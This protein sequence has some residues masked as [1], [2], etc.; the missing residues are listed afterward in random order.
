MITT[1]L[2]LNRDHNGRPC[3]KFI[4]LESQ[5]SDKMIFRVTNSIY[6]FDHFYFTWASWYDRN[7]SQKYDMS[8]IVQ[9]SKRC[10]L[11]FEDTQKCTQLWLFSVWPIALEPHPVL[12][13]FLFAR[14]KIQIIITILSLIT[15][16]ASIFFARPKWGMKSSTVLLTAWDHKIIVT[17]AQ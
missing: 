7:K 15:I 13:L 2:K 4:E 6:L 3:R 12:H 1:R 5:T 17:A 9:K 8:L 10:S 14:P 11:H 16:L